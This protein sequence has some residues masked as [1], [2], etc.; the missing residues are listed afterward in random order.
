MTVQGSSDHTA[1]N[2][3]KDEEN[4]C[5]IVILF[6]ERFDGTQLHANESGFLYGRNNVKNGI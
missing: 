4:E 3:Q 6:T 2:E 1:S 5:F